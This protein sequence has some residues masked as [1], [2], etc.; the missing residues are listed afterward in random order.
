MLYKSDFDVIIGLRV[1]RTVAS[2]SMRKVRAPQG[3]DAG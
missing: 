1:S 3:K 2:V